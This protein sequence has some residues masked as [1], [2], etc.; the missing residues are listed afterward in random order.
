MK[1]S[2]KLDHYRTTTI[3]TAAIQGMEA[4]EA[5]IH[6]RVGESGGRLKISGAG[7]AYEETAV[8]IEL[9]AAAAAPPGDDTR[10]RLKGIE[11]ELRPASSWSEDMWDM[12]LAVAALQ[13]LG[14]A[15]PT[16]DAILIGALG[17]SET[18]AATRGVTPVAKLAERLKRR[19]IVPIGNEREARGSGG[20][21]LQTCLRLSEI[22][23]AVAA[24]RSERT[25]INAPRVDLRTAHEL[26]D[27]KID[28][29]AL[30]A[31]EVAVTTGMSL[32]IM[33]DRTRPPARTRSAAELLV[34]LPAILPPMDGR[35][36]LEANTMH[37]IAGL[38]G[39]DG[40]LIRPPLRAP[41][42]TASAAAIAGSRYGKRPRPGEANL[43]HG[44]ALCLLDVDL[45]K[46]DALDAVRN[47]RRAGET[48][49][50]GARYAARFVTAA[51]ASTSES[52]TR[53]ENDAAEAAARRRSSRAGS[54]DLIVRMGEPGTDGHPKRQRRMT[55]WTSA[56]TAERIAEA[57]TRK[58]ARAGRAPETDPGA[59]RELAAVEA[60]AGPNRGAA[61]LWIAS[62]I[63]DLRGSDEP[64]TRSDVEDA[65]AM[66]RLDGRRQER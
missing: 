1:T 25:P 2:T 55:H 46:S 15:A 21:D 16:G 58:E 17:R 44:G 66:Q 56:A 8:Q 6:G 5:E 49:V 47:A 59:V 31:V 50:G 38:L 64:I 42:Y 65:R 29:D 52:G 57:R 36:A 32:L 34:R 9:A 41:H 43:A 22:G 26:A 14:H 45:F 28:D 61:T 11:L 35:T 12:P 10:E 30:R 37:S 7:K 51:T 20:V 18:I 23:A 48:R 39:P 53:A 24:E 3:Q 19:L 62:T 40:Q 4:V 60:A 33:E 13:L 27:L 63:R 54:F